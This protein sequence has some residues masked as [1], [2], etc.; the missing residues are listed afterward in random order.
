MLIELAERAIVPDAA[1]RAG[2]R[3]LLRSRL[4]ELESL[5]RNPEEDA[6][7]FAEQFASGPIAV[8]ADEANQQ[9][10]EVPAELFVAMLGSRLKYS[11]CVWPEGVASLDQA[12]EAML[13][14][15][16]ERAGIAD[17]QRV[18]D[19]GCGWG[20][21]S[22][23][24]AEQYPGCEVTAVSNS[25]TQKAFIDGRAAERGFEN[26]NVQTTNVAELKLDGP[27]DRVCSV[28][29]F[30]H[31]K[32]WAALLENVDR[33][34]APDGR[35]FAH[36]FCH[37]RRF[38]PFQ[39]RGKSDWMARHFFTGGV[40]P[41]ADVFQRLAGPLAPVEQW[42]VCGTDYA[43]TCRAWLDKLARNRSAALAALHG[44]PNARVALQR[45]RM[46][47]MA[48][49]ELFAYRGGSEWFVRHALLGRA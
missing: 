5:G 6:A 25:R 27:F 41:P 3:R 19:L 46:F 22:L 45:W 11:S 24:I 2:I 31:M 13:R 28:E 32:N 40:M 26:L 37:A 23:W 49:E 34:L 29:M 18:L 43:R 39:A 12:E 44:A 9:H 4:R 47:L 7:A 8:A 14:L 15:T 38:Y 35:F 42:E 17:G 21:L 30:E 48:C 20:S 36:V 1:L 16:C 33:W 10:Y